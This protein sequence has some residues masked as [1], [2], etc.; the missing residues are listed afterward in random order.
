MKCFGLSLIVAAVVLNLLYCL[1]A[2]PWVYP[3]DAK[4]QILGFVYLKNP[5]VPP[6]EAGQWGLVV[7]ILM[8]GG[9]LSLLFHRRPK[10]VEKK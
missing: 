1:W 4:D 8:L 6:L 2:C 5:A 3:Y 7:P 10:A 9:G